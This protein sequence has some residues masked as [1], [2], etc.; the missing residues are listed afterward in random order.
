MTIT[1]HSLIGTL[2]A[3]RI[4]NPY[5]SVPLSLIS[6]FTADSIPHWDSGCNWRKKS[7]KRLVF[8]S[9]LDFAV[10]AGLSFMIFVYFLHERD[11]ANLF[12]CVLAAQLPDWFV[13]P[14]LLYDLN[15]PPFSWINAIQKKF[16][17][18][19]K[20]IASGTFSQIVT[21]VLTYVVL[22]GIF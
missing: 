18:K 16:H 9:A 1:A 19:A 4:S 11:Y 14:S 2:I 6:H 10:G 7:K 22:Y 20:D 8:E 21:V 5:I 17:N 13:I 15:F 3:G 12:L